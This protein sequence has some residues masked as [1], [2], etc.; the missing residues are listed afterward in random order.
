M[1]DQMKKSYM[2]QAQRL[3]MNNYAIYCTKYQICKVPDTTICLSAN[4]D[5]LFPLI[6]LSFLT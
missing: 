4:K 3:D 5:E 6:L 1:T 2:F